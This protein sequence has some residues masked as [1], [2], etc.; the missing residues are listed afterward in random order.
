MA[1][2]DNDVTSPHALQDVNVIVYLVAAINC[3]LFCIFCAWHKLHCVYDQRLQHL[4]TMNLTHK[5]APTA[6]N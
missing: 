3:I 2:Y 1:C 4:Y 6:D 5:M